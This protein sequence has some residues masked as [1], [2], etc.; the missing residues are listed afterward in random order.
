MSS[1]AAGGAAVAERI[2]AG[3]RPR[4]LRLAVLIT[5]PIQYFKPV[6]QALAQGEAVELL[7]VFGC[8]HGLRTSLD[9]DFGVPF[10][11]DS[12]PAEGFPHGVIASVPL[13]ALSDWRQAFP[14]ARRA[15]VRIGAFRPDAVLVFAYTPAFITIATLLLRLRGHRLLLRA[16]GT[17]RAFVRSPLKALVKDL[18]LRGWYGMFQHVFPIGSDSDDHFHRL[19]VPSSRRTPVAYAVDVDFF[20]GQIAHW[21]PQRLALRQALDLPQD[22]SVLLWCGKITAVKN[23]ALLVAGLERL[24]AAERCG[25]WL[26]VVG[27]GLLREPFERQAQRLLPGRCRFEG[28]RNQSEL[29]RYYALADGLVFPSRQGETWGLVVNEALQFGLPV[30][31]SDHAGCARDLVAPPA[32]VP[33]GSAVFASDNPDALAAALRGWLAAP[34]VL[35][36]QQALQADSAAQADAAAM[37]SPAV[38]RLPHPADLA[39]AVLQKV[40][41]LGRR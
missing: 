38:R 28:F 31:V 11:W 23:P 36:T 25:L 32:R 34:R 27:D 30:L 19:G 21:R 6:F 3:G 35:P 15:V 13:A 10:A 29:G 26:V 39:G 33:A 17:D 14:L 20:A 18:G 2:G 8:D 4:P 41:R 7:V 22:G 5:H 1:S 9:P 40:C 16:D 24:E 37:G 12:S